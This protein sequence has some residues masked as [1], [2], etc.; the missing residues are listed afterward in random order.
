MYCE[1]K[2]NTVEFALAPNS[3]VHTTS[4]LESVY[5]PSLAWN[6]SYNLAR[7]IRR[8]RISFSFSLL[9]SLF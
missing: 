1:T 9:E 3:G 7:L 6:A 5:W 4:E 8:I 2:A